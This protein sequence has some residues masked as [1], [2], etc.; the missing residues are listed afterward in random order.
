MLLYKKIIILRHKINY[1]ILSFRTVIRLVRN[2][3]APSWAEAGYIRLARSDDDETN[4]GTDVTPQHGSACDGQT[5]PV[6]VIVQYMY[7]L[8]IW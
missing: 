7:L 2:S 1:L 8:C 6:K 3:W 5:D 4:C